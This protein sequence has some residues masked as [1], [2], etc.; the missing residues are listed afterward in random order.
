MKGFYVRPSKAL[1][2]GGGFFVPGLEGW[3]LPVA[4]GL[5][6]AVCLAVN[7]LASLEVAIG[8]TIT[9]AIGA[10]AVLTLILQG[11]FRRQLD[12]AAKSG[13][14]F[15]DVL[16]RQRVAF[17]DEQFERDYVESDAFESVGWMVETLLNIMGATAVVL[18]SRENGADGGGGLQVVLRAGDYTADENAAVMDENAVLWDD[19]QKQ[20]SG[21]GG[22]CRSV[23]VVE[24]HRVRGGS[25]AASVVSLFP[26]NTKSIAVFELPFL[27][28]QGQ[29][30][31]ALS[32]WCLFA[33]LRSGPSSVSADD[34]Y[35][36]DKIQTFAT[37]Q[38]NLT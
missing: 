38:T 37:V 27:S 7:H 5:F 34:A 22:P 2:V 36:L 31:G 6:F 28:S 10:I 14:L 15:A 17:V 3:R 12:M 33:G 26:A 29:T 13:E 32:E 23:R 16:E 25:E 18:A 35:W 4:G 30:G 24:R 11:L 1:E 21:D 9:E 8:Q 20:Q 19:G